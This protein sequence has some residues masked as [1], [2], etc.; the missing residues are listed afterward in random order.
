MAST[1]PIFRRDV[2][3]I[4]QSVDSRVDVL[5]LPVSTEGQHGLM[6]DW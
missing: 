5:L 6:K 2:E 1:L 4:G 3:F